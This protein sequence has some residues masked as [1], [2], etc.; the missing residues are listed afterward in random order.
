MFAAVARGSK[1]PE[2]S[3]AAAEREVKQIFE[4]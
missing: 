3:A 2:D 4:K 1:N